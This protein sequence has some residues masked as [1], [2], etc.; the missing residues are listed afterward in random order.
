MTNTKAGVTLIE[1]LILAAI[2]GIILA[3]GI[4][5]FQ[6]LYAVSK[7]EARYK[8]ELADK[9]YMAEELAKEK[10][11]ELEKIRPPA[12]AILV[13]PQEVL[14]KD[15][16]IVYRFFDEGRTHYFTNCSG[17]TMTAHSRLIGKVHRTEYEE[18]QTGYG[19]GK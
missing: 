10:E 3:I 2:A 19:E 9:P 1:L 18:I 7:I 12:P 5:K 17:A 6:E 15:G 16:C 8:K 13:V 4:P 11:Q 14:R